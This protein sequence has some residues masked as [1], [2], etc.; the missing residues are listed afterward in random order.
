LASSSSNQ[1]PLPIT[2][3]KFG[4]KESVHGL[5]FNWEVPKGFN[6]DFAEIEHSCDGIRFTLL[7]KITSCSTNCSYYISDKDLP[8]SARYYRIKLVKEFGTSYYSRI[9]SMNAQRGILPMLMLGQTPSSSHLLISLSA[10]K[11]DHIIFYFLN[12]LGQKIKIIP[13]QIRAGNQHISLPV[14]DLRAGNYQV[15]GLSSS[16]STNPLI[17]IKP[18]S[19]QYP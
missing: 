10:P 18:Y 9:V 15:F 4:L 13:M 12:N 3:V 2:W 17:F 8:L 16:L 1:N 14:Y 5:H 19:F 7:K 6:P 11:A